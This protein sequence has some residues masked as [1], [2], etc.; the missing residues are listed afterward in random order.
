MTSRDVNH[1]DDSTA[2]VEAFRKRS[3]HREHPVI[4]TMTGRYSFEA[5]VRPAFTNHVKARP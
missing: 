3:D 5:T 4:P 1:S 2:D